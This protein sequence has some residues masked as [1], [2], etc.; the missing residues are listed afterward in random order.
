MA[1]GGLMAGLAILSHTELLLV[2]LGGLFAAVTLSGII[3]TGWFKYHPDPHRHRP[4]G[5]PDGPAAS[6]L[7]T[8]RLGGGDDHRAVLD[9][10]RASRSRSAWACSTPTS[11]AMVERLR[12]DAR[13]SRPVLVC[14]AGLRRASAARALLGPGRRACWSTDRAPAGRAR[15]GRG[16]GPLRRA[17][18]RRCPTVSTWWSTSPGLAPGPPAVAR[19]RPPRRRRG[20]RRGRVRL[21]AARTRRRAVAGGHRHERQDD[22]RADARVDPARRR[23]ARRG[24]GQRRRLGHRRG[25]RGPAVR[26]ARGRAVELPAA[27]VARRS[28]PRPARCSTWPRTTSTGTARWPPTREAKARI[29]PAT[30]RSATSTTRS[31]RRAARR[32]P[33][34]RGSASPWATRPAPGSSACARRR[35]LVDRA[36]GRRRSS[37]PVGRRPPGR[38][39]TTSPT[40]WRRPR[41]PARTA[42]S[43]PRSPPACAPSSPTRT[44]T[45]SCRASAAS[46]T[47]TTARPPTRTPRRASLTAY[48]RGRVDRRRPAQG[49]A[50]RRTRRRGRRIGSPGSCCW[51]STAALIARGTAATRPGCPVIEVSSTDDGAMTEVVRAAAGL[52][53]PGDTVL[54]AP[55]AASY[56]MFAGYAARGEAFAAAVRELPATSE[57]A[58]MTALDA[59]SAEPAWRSSARTAAIPAAGRAGAAVPRPPVRLGPAAAARRRRA[60]RLRYADGGVDDDRGLA[61]RRQRP[62]IWA[63][64]IKEAEFVA[65]GVPC[66]GSPCCLPPRAYRLL[67]YPM[68]ALALVA[69]L[70]VLVPGIGVGVYGAR[71]WIDL[72][73]FQLQPSEFAQGRDAAVGRRPAG[74]QAAAGHA[75]PGPP[76]VPPAAARLRARRRPGHARARPRHDAAASC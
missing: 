55:A 57:R 52:A 32:A 37:S 19:R 45:S 12:P 67:A 63:Q 72:G 24:G 39:R 7:R 58:A 44:A 40:R 62:S 75:A 10:R 30:W 51:A 28:R 53:R 18:R 49:R 56:D 14:G 70:A 42:S 34:P 46:A 15:A 23:A 16:R 68:L 47:S 61:P 6:P 60:A 4:A 65:I 73:P 27:L 8:R 3:Q 71:R 25:H 74:A 64:V 69:L 50:G 1:L 11:S 31:S 13:R 59:G 21:A 22:D 48:D 26:R 54:L 76:P 5:V 9:R 41:W 20:D 29:W 66:S 43:R 36:F 17:A 2:V 38:A 35:S 33:A